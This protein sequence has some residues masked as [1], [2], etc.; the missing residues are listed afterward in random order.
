MS[1]RSGWFA[2]ALALWLS[3][4]SRAEAD[5]PPFAATLSCQPALGPGRILCELSARARRGKLVWSDAL[6][7]RAPAFARPLRSRLVAQLD[8]SAAASGAWARL[9]LVASAPGEGKLELLARGV[10]CHDA[11]TGEW[12]A[13]VQAPVTVDIR[14]PPSAPRRGP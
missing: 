7:V 2:L 5:E 12:C 10:I 9:A 11:A 13:P 6:V 4:A 8:S 1:A 14:V 3:A